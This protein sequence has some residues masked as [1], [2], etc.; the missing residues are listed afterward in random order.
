MAVNGVG[1]GFLQHI[2][3]WLPDTAVVG[4]SYLADAF[5]MDSFRGTTVAPRIVF[6]GLIRSGLEDI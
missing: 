2:H 5:Q 4:I 6:S 1:L 3:A